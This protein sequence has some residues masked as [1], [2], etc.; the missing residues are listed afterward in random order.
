MG[1]SDGVTL[2][3]HRCLLT[4]RSAFVAEILTSLPCCLS[5]SLSLPFN[6]TVLKNLLAVISSG[7]SLSLGRDDLLN[8]QNAANLLQIKLNNLN[9]EPSNKV[10]HLKVDGNETIQ[11][12]YHQVTGLPKAAKPKILPRK[13]KDLLPRPKPQDLL[14]Q[15]IAVSEQKQDVNQSCLSL[16]KETR[17]ATSAVSVR[18]RSSRKGQRLSGT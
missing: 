7:V 14:P 16:E 8:V 4:S 13:L 12:L 11:D 6:G 9:V 2:Q 17:S 3:Y 10:V 15:G 18:T 1:S 5:P